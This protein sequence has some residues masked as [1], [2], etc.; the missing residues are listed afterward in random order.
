MKKQIL[1]TLALC[2]GMVSYNYGQEYKEVLSETLKTF[3]ETQEP[4]EKL[5]QSNR[6][7][8]I[9]KKFNQEWSAAYYAA[10][11]KILLNYDEPDNNK[12]DAY[13]DEADDLLLQAIDLSDKSNKQVQSEIHALQAMIANARIGV[14]PE[15]RWM[16]YGKPFSEH[17][18][19]A[20]ALNEANP[21][22][23]F[24][25]GTSLFYTPQAF[26]GGK[27]KALEYF[28]KAAGYFAT[29]QQED[30]TMPSWGK[31]I[32]EYY[33]GECKSGK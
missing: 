22:I 2:L 1:W 33:I 12:K 11:S 23:Y 27:K 16:K 15:K 14:N 19:K 13:L 20:K 6:L 32:N 8:L 25:K 28:E 29:A 26:G 30:I 21:R 31:E 5:N 4:S 17:L 9:A 24:L 10:W 18:D 7:S 3:N